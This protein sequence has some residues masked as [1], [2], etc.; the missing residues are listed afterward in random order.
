MRRID[1][2]IV[3]CT[4]TKAGRDYAAKD[5]D[6]WHRA[7]GWDGIGY[8]YVVCLD[9]SVEQGRPEEKVGAHC[10]GHNKHSIGVVYVGGLD[11]KGRPCDTRTPQQKTA[12]AHLITHLKHRFPSAHVYGHRDL[13]TKACPCFNAQMEYG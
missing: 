2:I 9:G 13:A 7:N 10:R 12:L 4:A 5:I 3:H 11:S 1:E 8:H 6:A